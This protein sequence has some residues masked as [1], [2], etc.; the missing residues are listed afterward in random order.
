MTKG[1]SNVHGTCCDRRGVRDIFWRQV[2]WE[3]DGKSAGKIL[4]SIN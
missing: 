2:V 1:A 4:G 3:V